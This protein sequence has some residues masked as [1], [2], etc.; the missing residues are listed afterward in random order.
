[1]ELWDVL[2]E[3]RQK[4]GK[5]IVRGEALNP[6]EYHLVVFA[7]IRNSQGKFIISKRTPNKTSPNKWEVTGGSA[8]AGDDSITAVKREVKEELGIDL[9]DEGVLIRSVKHNS[10]CSYFSDIWLFEED[11]DMEAI[12]CQPEEV[13]EARL[14]TKEEIYSLVKEDQFVA[15]NPAVV[16][17]LAFL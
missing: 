14:A 4:T 12:V 8:L 7:F 17:C 6:N 9:T 1:M 13:S 3:N 11:I 16:G 15:E 2:D 5:T 10:E